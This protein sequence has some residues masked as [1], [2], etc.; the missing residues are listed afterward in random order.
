MRPIKTENGPSGKRGFG[1]ASCFSPSHFGPFTVAPSNNPEDSEN[2]GNGTC[3][4]LQRVQSAPREGKPLA[5]PS[6]QRYVVHLRVFTPPAP[7]N[8]VYACMPSTALHKLPLLTL[9]MAADADSNVVQFTTWPSSS[10]RQV[11]LHHGYS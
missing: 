2:N 7:R 8:S 5:P 10:T 3:H 11:K 1:L 4:H 9:A 6:W